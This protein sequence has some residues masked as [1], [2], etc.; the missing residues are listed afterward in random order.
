MKILFTQQI[1]NHPN[2]SDVTRFVDVTLGLIDGNAEKLDIIFQVRHYQGENPKPFIK[3]ITEVID[4]NRTMH[5]RDENFQYIENEG[6]EL[7]E[8]GDNIE[9]QYLKQPAFD[10][11]IG[12]LFNSNVP[13]Q[14]ILGGH[15]A[16]MVVDGKFD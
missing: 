9:G 5:V 3:A 13:M 2:N 14:F 16:E 15:I 6:W 8:D 10:Y 11:I 4:N 7:N 12:L 1:S